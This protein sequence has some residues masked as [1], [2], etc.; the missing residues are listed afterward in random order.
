MDIVN[1][2]Q[3]NIKYINKKRLVVLLWVW[4][5]ETQNQS[6]FVCNFPKKD[7]KELIDTRSKVNGKGN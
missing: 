1:S 2:N 5:M 7:A 6:S 4:K 3:I